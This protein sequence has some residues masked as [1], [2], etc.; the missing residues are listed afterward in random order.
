MWPQDDCFGSTSAAPED[1][2]ML[3]RDV[4]FTNLGPGKCN[5]INGYFAM[6]KGNRRH[7][8]QIKQRIVRFIPGLGGGECLSVIA[9]IW[10]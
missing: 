3:L 6:L 7:R 10:N 1:E 5:N 9:L 4:F 2:L 8:L